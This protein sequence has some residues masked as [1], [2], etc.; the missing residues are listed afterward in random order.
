MMVISDFDGTVVTNQILSR[1]T[2]VS[3]ELENKNVFRNQAS[4]VSVV[5]R[6]HV[7]L[8]HSY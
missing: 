2:V 6:K 4:R 8:E 5:I 3:F 1:D 7:S